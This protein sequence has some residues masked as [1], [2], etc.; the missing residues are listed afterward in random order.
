MA[1]LTYVQSLSLDIVDQ[2]VFD[3]WKMLECQ[4]SSKIGKPPNTGP[5]LVLWQGQHGRDCTVKTPYSNEGISVEASKIFG[6][7]QLAIELLDFGIPL[8]SLC[9]TAIGVTIGI[10]VR[11]TIDE[12]LLRLRH[13]DES[14]IR[15]KIRCTSLLC[16]HK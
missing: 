12:G 11:T 6:V 10:A 8:R 2:N 5:K 9:C 3:G 16:F 4:N 15:D 7:S 14:Q 13:G 1:N